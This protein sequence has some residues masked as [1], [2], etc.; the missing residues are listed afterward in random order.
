MSQSSNVVTTHP[1]AGKQKHSPHSAD[2]LECHKSIEKLQFMKGE[3]AVSEHFTAG[4]LE[5]LL[6]S[7]EKR[8]LH[9]VVEYII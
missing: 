5:S 3:T 7:H 2:D 1:N 4:N 9:V 8:G 6:S